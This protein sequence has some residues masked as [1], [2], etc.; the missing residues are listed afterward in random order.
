MPPHLAPGLNVEEA[1]HLCMTQCLAQCCRG[2]TILALQPHEVVLL[3]Q[4]ADEFSVT[5]MV[6]D[7][8]GGV[9]WVRFTDHPGNHCPMLD[10][11]TSSCRIYEERPQR[12]RDFP[13]RV[14]E[15]CIISGG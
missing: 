1:S 13:E 10:D 3:K 4:R 11:V 5:L 7:R 2:A 14:T 8:P 9:G 6:E 15:G 12:C